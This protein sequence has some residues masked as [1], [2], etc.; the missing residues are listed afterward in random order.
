MRLGYSI[1]M[2][3]L[4]AGSVACSS[5]TG[6]TGTGG[7]GTGGATGSGGDDSTVSAGG[8]TGTGGDAGTGGGD[9]GD[10]VCVTENVE[11]DVNGE[12][13]CDVDCDVAFPGATGEFAQCTISCVDDTDCGDLTCFDFD[14]AGICLHDCLDGNA[15]PGSS[16]YVCDETANFCDPDGVSG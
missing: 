5:S 1:L 10:G 16:E 8:G 6:D 9:T 14:G 11:V 15:C 7:G 12:A 13:F 4:A 3:A 2:A